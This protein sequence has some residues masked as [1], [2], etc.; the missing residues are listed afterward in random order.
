MYL[1]LSALVATDFSQCLLVAS[2]HVTMPLCK[3]TNK[4]DL[5]GLTAV[6]RL[7][8]IVTVDRVEIVV[9]GELLFRDCLLGLQAKDSI[10]VLFLLGICKFPP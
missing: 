7:E 8:V 10:D 6:N 3:E 1:R 4:M 5:A 2:G 9:I